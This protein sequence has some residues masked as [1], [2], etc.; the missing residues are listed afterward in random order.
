M[1]KPSSVVPVSSRGGLWDRRFDLAGV[2]VSS[3]S[4]LYAP[5]QHVLANGSGLGEVH[6]GGYSEYARLPE[7]WVVPMPDG[8][9]SRSAMILGTAGFTAGLALQRLVDNN[10]LPEHGPMLVT[11]ATLRSFSSLKFPCTSRTPYFAVPI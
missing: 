10:Q 4:S 1:S 6:D 5:G 2:V 3:T 11:G 7:D 9:D 8:L